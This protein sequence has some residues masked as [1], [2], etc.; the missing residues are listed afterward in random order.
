MNSAP[1]R[2]FDFSMLQLLIFSC[3]ARVFFLLGGQKKEPNLPAGRQG[4][5]HFFPKAP[6]EKNSSTLLSQ[7]ANQLYGAGFLPIIATIELYQAV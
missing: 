6:P 3:L 5:G 7:L 1:W 2:V 4:K